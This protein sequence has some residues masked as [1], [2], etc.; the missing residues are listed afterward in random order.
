VHVV[1]YLLPYQ[2]AGAHVYTSYPDSLAINATSDQNGDAV[3]SQVP[4]GNYSI[5]VVA[6]RGLQ[7]TIH[8]Q[9]IDATNLTIRVL[10]LPELLIILI[11]PVTAA[12]I[13]VVVA[14]RKERARRK[15]WESITL[16]SI[17]PP[18]YPPSP[19]VE[20]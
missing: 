10:G 14:V 4:L 13:I 6:P 8:S 9:I 1:G 12:V 17:A 18:S 5:R 16:P 19:S 3:F 20:P 15:M 11:V 7:S 2:V